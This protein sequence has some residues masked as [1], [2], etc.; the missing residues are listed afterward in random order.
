MDSFNLKKLNEVEGKEKHRVEVSNKF[1]AL[2]D[3]EREI[4]IKNAWETIRENKKISAKE[5]LGYCQ[6]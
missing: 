1:V 4:E 3:L 6:L 5:S 2:E